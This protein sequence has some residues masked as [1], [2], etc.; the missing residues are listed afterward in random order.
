MS[1]ALLDERPFLVTAWPGFGFTSMDCIY[2][3][4]FFFLSL[5]SVERA[6]DG[7]PPP[8]QGTTVIIVKSEE[9]FALENVRNVRA[10]LELAGARVVDD[11]RD[12]QFGI[13]ATNAKPTKAGALKLLQET[14]LVLCAAY[15]IILNMFC[16][17]II[18]FIV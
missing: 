12:A 1:R 18:F 3:F 17:V 4:M 11:A 9:K 5:C 13:V 8:L 15:V 16:V 10:L 6:R 14:Y 2:I 7:E